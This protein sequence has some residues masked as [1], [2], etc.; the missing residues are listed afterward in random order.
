MTTKQQ[1]PKQT[2]ILNTTHASQ[3]GTAIGEYIENC[4]LLRTQP[5][6]L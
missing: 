2:G 3:N 6:K 5:F 1:I 4:K